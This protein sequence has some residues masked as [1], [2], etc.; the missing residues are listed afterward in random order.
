MGRTLDRGMELNSAIL[1]EE[2]LDKACNATE[3]SA[4]SP[5]VCRAPTLYI[6]DSDEKSID[7][8]PYLEKMPDQWHFSDALLPD[9]SDMTFSYGASYLRISTCH[10]KLEE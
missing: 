3:S 5:V 8:W 10:C 1:H 4:V 6:S 7:E 9:L 2:N